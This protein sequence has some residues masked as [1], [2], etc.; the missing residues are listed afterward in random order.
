MKTPIAFGHLGEKAYWYTI[1]GVVERLREVGIAEEPRPTVYLLHDQTE[2]WEGQGARPSWIVIHSAGEPASIVP[3][4]RQAI[5][6][7][8]KNQPIW[9]VETLDEIVDRQLSTPRQTTA[10]M[11][12]FALLALLL[13]SLGITECSPTP[14]PSARARS[15]C[16]WR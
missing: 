14:L 3:V 13:A 1:V 11:G 12:A 5:R 4:I 15:A 6:S 16:A 2:Q 9:R 8:D 7:V 10:L